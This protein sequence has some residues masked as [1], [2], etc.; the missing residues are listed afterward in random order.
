MIID[1]NTGCSFGAKEKAEEL[2]VHVLNYLMKLALTLGGHQGTSKSTTRV[3]EL[4]VN[5]TSV[6]R[7]FLSY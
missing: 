7:T 2:V 1:P 6:N 4:F 3:Q 5:Q